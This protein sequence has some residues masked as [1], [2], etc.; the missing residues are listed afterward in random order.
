[1]KHVI[2]SGDYDR[3]ERYLYERYASKRVRGEWFDLSEE[4]VAEIKT[5]DFLFKEQ[6]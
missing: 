3:A 1:L 5:I 4:E 2:A 6:P